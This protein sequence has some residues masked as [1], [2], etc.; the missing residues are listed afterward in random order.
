VKPFRYA[1]N[2]LC[3]ESVDLSD[4]ARRFGTPLYVYSQTSLEKQLLSFDA[5]F[6][7]IPHLTCFAVKANSNLA[8]LRLY[9][10]LGAGFDIVSGGEMYRVLQAGG[11]PGKI[12]FSGVGKTPSEIDMGLA[13]G[14]LQFNVESTAEMG[15]IEARARA[16]KVLARVSLRVNP[17]VDPQTHPYI[18][19][20][21]LEH[22]FGVSMQDAPALLK[23]AAA[24]PHLDVAGI[25]F[26]IGS[27]ITTVGPFVSSLAQM[28][29]LVLHLRAS[30]IEIGR[31]DL[32]GGLGITYDNERPPRPAEYARAVLPIVRELNCRLLLE[33]GRAIVG[34][35]GALI[36]RVVLTKQNG[37]KNFIVVDAGMSE[38]IRPS[39]YGSYHAILPAKRSRAKRVLSD[40]VGP[41]CESSDFLARGREMPAVRSGD[42]L[43]VMSA[44]AYGFVL[45][46]NYNSRP[47]VAEVLVRGSR[48]KL[49]R[50]RETWEDLVRGET[51]IPL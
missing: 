42:L 19:T 34:N 2:R 49:I 1:Q 4:L 35:A 39:F 8:I 36:T 32:G 24:S 28:R 46:S 37:G 7:G 14:I 15:M 10:K 20:G 11:S 13:K 25:G 45:S 27:Q 22:K 33:P 16:G 12:V 48:V 51:S 3:C 40:V 47:R 18:A 9:H 41:I 17:D 21:M 43:A 38:L 29:E 44:G 23:A 26:H 5:A 30:G 31:L 50:Q 6:A